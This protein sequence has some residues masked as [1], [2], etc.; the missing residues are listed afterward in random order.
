MD[1]TSEIERVLKPVLTQNNFEL[2]ET[3]YRREDGKWV[4]RIFIDRLAGGN[5]TLDDCANASG[6][7]GD[8]LDAANV[9]DVNY[10]LEVS[11]PGVNRPLKN[12][13]HFMKAVGQNIKVSLSA[14]L[15][16]LSNQKNFTGV[17]LKLE[18]KI[19][20]VDDA[21]SGK[22]LIPLSAVQKAHLDL[23]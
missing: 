4:V 7:A 23:I 1:K 10:V 16:P 2:I 13:A 12:E 19:L 6:I 20:V 8:A 11:S 18:G 21:T 15:S 14:P 3:Q 22:V 9:V 17:L 5:V